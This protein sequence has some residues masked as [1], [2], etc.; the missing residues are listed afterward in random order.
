MPQPCIAYHVLCACDS[1]DS[2]GLNVVQYIPSGTQSILEHK[3]NTLG[4][5]IGLAIITLYC[6]KL[7][8]VLLHFQVPIVS[9]C[10]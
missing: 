4:L 6:I 10:Y 3:N 8:E 7:M 1:F 2:T 5:D 9:M